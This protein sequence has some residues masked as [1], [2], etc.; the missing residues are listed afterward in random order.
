MSNDPAVVA[1]KKIRS[2]YLYRSPRSFEDDVKTIRE[3]HK[4]L[5]DELAAAKEALRKVREA[6]PE[7]I[8]NCKTCR[9]I[10]SSGAGICHTESSNPAIE[11]IDNYFTTERSQ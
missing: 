8:P 11:I 3:A 2:A 6:S 10:G 1:A 4:S 9:D 7:Y 5:H